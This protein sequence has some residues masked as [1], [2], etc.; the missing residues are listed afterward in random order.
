MIYLSR[1]EKV[2]RRMKLQCEL[3]VSPADC[4][5]KISIHIRTLLTVE[6]CQY[7]KSGSTFSSSEPVAASS[8]CCRLGNTL[9]LCSPVQPAQAMPERGPK[10]LAIDFAAN[11]F[12]CLLE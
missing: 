9:C 10:S 8:D 2:N 3:L 6:L 1:F 4:P 12:N 11:T 5:L 7:C